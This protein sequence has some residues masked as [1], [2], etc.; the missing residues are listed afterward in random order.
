MTPV[1]VVP[2]LDP[3]KYLQPG[4]RLG[5]P[6]AS[7][8]ELTFQRGKEALR[9][10]VVIHIAYRAHGRAHVHLLAPI[11]KGNAGVLGGFNRSSQHRL[12]NG[13]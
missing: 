13:F 2:S 4:F 7:C 3:G 12:L 9:H 6:F 10:G 5:I 8:D 1:R 11:A